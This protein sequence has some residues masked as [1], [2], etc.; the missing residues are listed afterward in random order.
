MGSRWSTSNLGRFTAGKGHITHYLGGCV[1]LG[2]TK[3]LVTTWVRTPDRSLCSES[4]YWL[5]CP[6]RLWLQS[7]LKKKVCGK[8]FIII[9]S[10]RPKGPLHILISSVCVCVC[11]CL[12]F[13]H[14]VTRKSKES[15][16]SYSWILQKVFTLVKGTCSSRTE[17]CNDIKEVDRPLN[18]RKTV[19]SVVLHQY[20]YLSSKH[21]SVTCYGIVLQKEKSK[22]KGSKEK[23][24]QDSKCS[25]GSVGSFL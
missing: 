13:I 3:I 15:A 17:L 24:R 22:S 23:G 16:I 4:L 20:N 6:N 11:V 2:A 9:V 8:Y 5:R 14:I 25:S 12:C 7:Y 1:G 18:W 10:Y 21:R 19:P